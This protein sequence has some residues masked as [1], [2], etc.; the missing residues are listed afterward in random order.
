MMMMAN[1]RHRLLNVKRLNSVN[2]D[3]DDDLFIDI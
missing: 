3:E 2:V 1:L